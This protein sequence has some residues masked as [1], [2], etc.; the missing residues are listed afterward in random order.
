MIS[1]NQHPSNSRLDHTGQICDAPSFE[2]S[3]VGKYFVWNR[4]DQGGQ[5]SVYRGWDPELQREVAIKIGNEPCHQELSAFEEGVLLARIHSTHVADVYDVG[6]FDGYPFLVMEYV[7]GFNLHQVVASRQLSST[8]IV[9]IISQVAQA[10]GSAHASGVLHL[11]LKPENVMLNK[12]NKVKLVDF[13]AGWRVPSRG[14]DLGDPGCFTEEFAAPEQ[15]VDE[16]DPVDVRT[17][18]YG[19]SALL[20]FLLTGEPPQ[21]WNTDLQVR[22][23]K[24]TRE[25]KLFGVAARG[26]SHSRAMRFQDTNEFLNALKTRDRKSAVLIIAIGLLSLVLGVL[27]VTAS[28]RAIPQQVSR[29]PAAVTNL[30]VVAP[31]AEEIDTYIFLWTKAGGVKQIEIE[32]PQTELAKI[33]RLKLADLPSEFAVLT[34]TSFADP[35]TVM[36]SAKLAF[37]ISQVVL[38]Q[39]QLKQIVVDSESGPDH[40]PFLQA[41]VDGLRN[42]IKHFHLEMHFGHHVPSMCVDMDR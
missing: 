30:E 35:V 37:G 19:L 20:W 14:D 31:P 27:H 12:V 1:A 33:H 36:Q 40:S 26:L 42:D 22:A 18:I 4:I 9:R 15:V 13:G 38:K 32:H 2:N 21:P 23:A 25:R 5:G 24:N 10:V 39:E 6:I 29:A 34:L 41:I 16:L 17:D 8:E 28:D 3:R 11:D 7:D